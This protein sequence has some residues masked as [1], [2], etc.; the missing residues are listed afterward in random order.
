MGQ[1]FQLRTFHGTSVFYEPERGVYHVGDSEAP[2]LSAE[3]TDETVE[4]FIGSE[5]RKIYFTLDDEGNFITVKEPKALKYIR[6]FDDTISIMKGNNYLSALEGN[7]KFGLMPQNITWEHFTLETIE[8][9]PIEPIERPP[10]E[11]IERPPEFEAP[12]IASSPN[13]FRPSRTEAYRV[14]FERQLL[15]ELQTL[16]RNFDEFVRRQERAEAERKEN[17]SD[18]YNLVSDIERLLDARNEQNAAELSRM[19][20][21]LEDIGLALNKLR[22][23]QDELKETVDDINQKLPTAEVRAEELQQLV[24]DNWKQYEALTLKD[25]E[26]LN[27]LADKLR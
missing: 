11:P 7:A 27:R 21:T 20:N 13:F 6:N 3:L 26:L 22:R 9:S 10:T 4:L 15:M 23:L 16:N 17:A 19:N 2:R 24:A 12:R 8:E 14:A 18:I 1:K 25:I 5:G